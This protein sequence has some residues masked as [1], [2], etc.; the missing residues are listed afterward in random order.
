MIVAMQNLIPDRLAVSSEKNSTPAP[1][2]QIYAACPPRRAVD[3]AA[4]RA[5]QQATPADPQPSPAPA[6]QEDEPAVPEPKLAPT[7]VVDPPPNPGA[8][9]STFANR[10]TP[11]QAHAPYVPLFTS[12]P[13]LGVPFSIKNPSVHRR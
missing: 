10:C 9:Q 11:S 1:A 6:Q 13:D 3:P 2:P 4:W 5:P 12:V 7:P 8:S